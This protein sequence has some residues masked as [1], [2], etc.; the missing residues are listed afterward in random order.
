MQRPEVHHQV[1]D[2]EGSLPVRCR[3]TREDGRRGACKLKI[4]ILS[5]IQTEAF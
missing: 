4:I 2:E 1:P 3:R 5:W